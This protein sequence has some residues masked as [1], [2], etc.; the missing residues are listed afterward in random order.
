MPR[1][2][3]INPNTSAGVTD[4]LAAH[5]APML[6]ASWHVEAVTA[7]F[8]PAYISSEVAYTVAAHAALDA[9][10]SA[11]STRPDAVLIGCF[12]DPGLEA[13]REV[14]HMPVVGLAEAAMQEAAQAGRFVI[15]TGGPRWAAILKR[16]AQAAG[17]AAHFAGMQILEASG[18]EL[19]A[20]RAHAIDLLG[21]ACERAIDASRPDAIILGGAAL[22]GIGDIL[23][24]K[25]GLPV[26]DSVSAGARALQAA[27]GTATA[28]PG[29][30][31]VTYTGISD[32]L[33]RLVQRS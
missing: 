25:L 14:A 28:A 7:A 11:V 18:A 2:L 1:A 16:R 21:Q 4:M 9:F 17:L 23:A 3:V 13:L 12:G 19:A 29:A 6:G 22:A 8:G 10:A 32:A 31:G 15:V 27:A 20:D 30:D 33:A 26:I 24:T 5:I